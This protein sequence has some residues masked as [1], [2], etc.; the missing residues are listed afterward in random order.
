MWTFRFADAQPQ[1]ADPSQLEGE[2]DE[3]EEQ[4]VR[5]EV[6]TALINVLPWGIS[7]VFHAALV[8][9]AI[10]VVWT[11]IIQVPEEDVIIPLVTLSPTPGAPLQMQQTE[12]VEQQTRERRTV[13]RPQPTEANPMAAAV[14]VEVPII[15]VDGAAAAKAAP[16]GTT[17]AGGGE[18][19][20]SVFGLGGNARRIAFVIDA[21]GSLIDTF[22]FVIAE[23]KRT[24][25]DL[26]DRQAFTIIF[27]SGDGTIEVPPPGLHPAN[28]EIKSRVTAWIDPAS[29]N[30]VTAGRGSPVGAIQQALRYRPELIFL[31]S[32]NITGQGQ[33]EIEQQQLLNEIRR[34][35]TAGT[36]INTIQF[37]YPDP[38][39]RMGL[40][41]TMELIA[42]Q[43]GG[44]YKFISAKD[45]NLR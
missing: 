23:L 44:L 19:Q 27:F 33:Y 40:K 20:T 17:L 5:D 9:L 12:R 7:T 26:S 16:F 8:L 45:L 22:P 3:R 30:V 28:A 1:P 34:A 24:I 29:H 2:H 31:L 37:I 39:E 15:G 6:Q 25:A 36:K 32:D 11:T 21:T 14:Q 41:G 10:F 13:E 43:S 18:F 4:S 42:E 35:N 38:L